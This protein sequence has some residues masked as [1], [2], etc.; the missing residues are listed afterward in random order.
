MPERRGKNA[1]IRQALA[2]SDFVGMVSGAVGLLLNPLKKSWS[3][4]AREIS[5][6]FVTLEHILKILH[7]AGPLQKE[8]LIDFRMDCFDCHSIIAH[9]LIGVP[10]IRQ[11]QSIE[12]WLQSEKINHVTLKDLGID[13]QVVHQTGRGWNSPRG[14]I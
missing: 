5:F 8:K 13:G 10:E 3:F 7:T 9:K 1:P 11:A 12:H 6:F 4:S 14:S 2:Q